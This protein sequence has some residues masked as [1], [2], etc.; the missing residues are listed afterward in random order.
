MFFRGLGVCSV[1]AFVVNAVQWA[2]YEWVMG[3]LKR[4][5][6]GAGEKVVVGS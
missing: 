2:V 1:R 4:E 6:E 3:L 5:S